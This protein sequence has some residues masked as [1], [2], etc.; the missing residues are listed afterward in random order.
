MRWEFRT[1]RRYSGVSRE[2]T[3]GTSPTPCSRGGW[4]NL[5]SFRRSVNALEK[6]ACAEISSPVGRVHKLLGM[7]DPK[8]SQMGINEHAS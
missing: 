1:K 5:Q 8:T 3:V 4:L 6:T 2:P 7:Q